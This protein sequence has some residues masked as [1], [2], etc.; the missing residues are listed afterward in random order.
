MRNN[1]ILNNEYQ[2]ILLREARKSGYFEQIPYPEGVD[3][4]SR[5]EADEIEQSI[6]KIGKRKINNLFQMILLYDNITI[7]TFI[8]W[9]DYSKLKET[10]YIKIYT[11]DDMQNYMS[12]YFEDF[13]YNDAQNIKPALITSIKKIIS[14]YNY[15]KIENDTR[16]A[17]IIYDL[18]VWSKI[19]IYQYNKLIAENINMLSTNAYIF[20]NK[21]IA[22]VKFDQNIIIN[23]LQFLFDWLE[24][25]VDNLLWDINLS[26]SYNGIILNSE[27]N[28]DKIGLHQEE[29]P[30]EDIAVYR[31]LKAELSEI[32]GALPHADSLTEIFYMKEKYRNEIKRLRSVIDELEYILREFGRKKMIESAI[33]DIKKASKELE[34]IDKLDKVSKWTTYLSIPITVAETVLSIPP[35]TGITLGVLGVYAT[36]KTNNI[37]KRNNWI[38]V[39]R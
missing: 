15:C 18:Y 29:K 19:D 14:N 3:W 39:V 28:I 8:D 21:T 35:V 12:K 17:S 6:R 24:V 27:Y 30:K 37:K 23:Y 25:N 5:E 33:S 4:L 16:F 2:Y 20:D 26:N 36:T 22:Q 38:S 9:D 31:T 7:P 34:K 13:D 1:L 32:I 11:Y 10:G